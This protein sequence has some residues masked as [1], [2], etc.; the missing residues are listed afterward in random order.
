VRSGDVILQGGESRRF[1]HGVP[2]VLAGSLAPEL[3][4][5]RVPSDPELALV[6]EWL[7]EH[8]VNINVRQVWEE[9]WEGRP[10]DQGVDTPEEIPDEEPNRKRS[11]LSS[12][13]DEVPG[14]NGAS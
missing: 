6:S 14:E 1:V 9:V 10:G 7:L 12:E 4:P 3:H 2:R 8:R 5:S 13:A 11:K